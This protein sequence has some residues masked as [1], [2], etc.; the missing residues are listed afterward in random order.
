MERTFFDREGFASRLVLDSLPF[1][2][3]C[4]NGSVTFTLYCLFLDL[5]N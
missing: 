5:K 3:F 2:R 4:A 1:W